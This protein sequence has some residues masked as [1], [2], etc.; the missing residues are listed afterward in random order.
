MTDRLT[1]DVVPPNGPT[2]QPASV[3]Q[4]EIIRWRRNLSLFYNTHLLGYNN[5]NRIIKFCWAISR[6]RST[7]SAT[8]GVVIVSSIV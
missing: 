6:R 5:N 4:W 3:K 7:I 8:S 1:V 2:T